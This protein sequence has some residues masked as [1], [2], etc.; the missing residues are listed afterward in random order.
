MKYLITHSK[1]KAK[2]IHSNF[3]RYISNEVDW[4]E[5]LIIIPGQRGAGKTTLL[6]QRLKKFP[7][8]GIYL[9]LDDIYFEANRL[10][11]TI[12]NLYNAGYRSFY[13]DELHRY[14]YWAKDLKNAYD[15]YPDIQIIGTG[16]SIL[17]LSKGQADLSR[18][19][20][21][22]HLYG[23]SFREFL[24]LQYNSKFSVFSLE[25]ILE[26]CKLPYFRTT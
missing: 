3:E 1:N 22:Y 11:N 19:A 15:S 10:I 7:E 23:L 6:L 9:S 20:A 24:H 8:K 12:K 5:R 14:E 17:E 4:N 2:K 21:V 16:S 18:R 26:N 25:D 13:L